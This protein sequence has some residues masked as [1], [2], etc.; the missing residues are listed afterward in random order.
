[1]GIPVA[2]FDQTPHEF[3]MRRIRIL[4]AG[5]VTEFDT[6][7]VVSWLYCAVEEASVVAFGEDVVVPVDKEVSELPKTVAGANPLGLQLNFW[8]LDCDVV[9][10]SLIIKIS[11]NGH[12]NNKRAN[13]CCSKWFHQRILQCE[14]F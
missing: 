11:E 6:P 3:W 9:A 1:V 10:C 8:Q 13:N 7:G 2:V 4:D 12:R 14:L 5:G